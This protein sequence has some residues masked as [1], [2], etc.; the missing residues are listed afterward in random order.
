MRTFA[1]TFRHMC[2]WCRPFSMSRQSSYRTRSFRMSTK[3]RRKSSAT[4]RS[5]LWSRSQSS[6]EIRPLPNC[7]AQTNGLHN[8]VAN[9]RTLLI[10][11]YPNNYSGIE[12][13]N[14]PSNL[15]CGYRNGYVIPRNREKRFSTSSAYIG[16]KLCNR[17]MKP[18]ISEI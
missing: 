14:N 10:R 13:A 17:I 11:T 16:A 15:I 5:S 1:N 6:P 12:T 8:E 2:G 3:S 7:R 18:Y 9:C 4:V